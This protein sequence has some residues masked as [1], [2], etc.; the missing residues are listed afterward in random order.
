[1][2]LEK[3][4]DSNINQIENKKIYCYEKS[5]SYLEELRQKY[6]ILDQIEAVIDDNVRNQGV[7][8]F[9][10]RKITVQNSE[11]IERID[12]KNGVLLITSD[13]YNEAYEK[14]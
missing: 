14:L 8:E 12:W 1:M 13:Y 11:M 2:R 9:G 10:G 3:L 4:C 7:L 6:A 5:L